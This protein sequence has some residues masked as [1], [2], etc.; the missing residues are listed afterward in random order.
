MERQQRYQKDNPLVTQQVEDLVARHV[1]KG[2]GLTEKMFYIYE[3]PLLGVKSPDDALWV[4][5]HKLYKL[6]ASNR[7]YT[8]PQHIDVRSAKKN[9]SDIIELMS[10]PTDETDISM[11]MA[12]VG[13]TKKA[14]AYT[15]WGANDLTA[16]TPPFTVIAKLHDNNVLLAIQEVTHFIKQWGPY[17]QLERCTWRGA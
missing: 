14:Y 16:L 2:M 5:V 13:K 8:M 7:P 15:L 11:I 4:R 6:L 12:R 17:P 9:H 10:D 1:L 3:E